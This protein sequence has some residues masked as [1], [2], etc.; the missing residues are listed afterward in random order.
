[1]ITNPVS[2]KNTKQ[3]ILEACE[4]LKKLLSEQKNDNKTSFR[5]HILLLI[6]KIEA[7]LEE[8][9]AE[10]KDLSQ[11]IEDLKSQLNLGQ[12]IKFTFD[13]LQKLKEDIDKQ[14]S[15]FK[16]QREQAETE[17][18]QEKKWQ[19]ERIAKELEQKQW[20]TE[21][22]AKK[23]LKEVSEKEKEFSDMINEYKKLKSEA[24]KLP[25]LI[26]KERQQAVAQIIK[27]LKTDFENER[28]LLSQKAD[29]ERKLFEQKITDLSLRL[30]EQQK[31]NNALKQQLSISSE[32]IKQLAIAALRG[33]QSQEDVDKAS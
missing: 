15:N 5:S 31:E 20:E 22:E 18:G 25:D 3:E 30:A 32:Q 4:Q 11:K 33:K 12:Q 26:E 6:E 28:A 7:I 16:R 19:K 24:E 1:M 27:Q 14:E 2:G 10:V 23:R 9:S 21:L 8:K 13:H 17:F 29:S